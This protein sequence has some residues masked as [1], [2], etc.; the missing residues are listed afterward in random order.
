VVPPP[1]HAHVVERVAQL[2]ENHPAGTPVVPAFQVIG[3]RV[4][5][6]VVTKEKAQ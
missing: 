2:V 1:F 5:V 4:P 3:W 6:Q